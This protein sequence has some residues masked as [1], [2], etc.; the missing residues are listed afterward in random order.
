MFTAFAVRTYRNDR[1]PDLHTASHPSRSVDIPLR[2][3]RE[4]AK[5]THVGVGS[6][7]IVFGDAPFYF[8]RTPRPQDCSQCY[9]LAP[10][11]LPVL[12]RC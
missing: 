10:L 7:P 2:A 12:Q 6:A 5:M 9:T 11:M 4:L 1:K 3:S 8:V